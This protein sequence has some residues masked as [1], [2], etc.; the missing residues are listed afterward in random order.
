MKKTAL[1][2]ILICLNLFLIYKNKELDRN[3][4]NP[5]DSFKIENL[6]KKTTIKN[7]DF[8]R[9]NNE[10]TKN[11]ENIKL[12]SL[13]KLL[14]VEGDTI[15]TKDAFDKNNV[16]FRYSFL[17][18]ETCY[19]FEIDFLEKQKNLLNDNFSII[20]Y[21]KTI[22]DLIYIQERF[23]KNGIPNVKVYSLLSN[24]LGT[25]IDQLNIPYYFSINPSLKMN[26]FF[27]PNQKKSE[28]SKIYL[29]YI[30]KLILDSNKLNKNL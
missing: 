17:N 19:E 15:L 7:L 18:C 24:D 13:L 6:K 30:M 8:F 16:V 28:Y 2:I 25:P 11:N 22:K 29:K 14:T 20:T 12:S 1:L 26:N 3:Y 21:Q 9:K 4:Q 10:Q 27:V 5:I 23:R